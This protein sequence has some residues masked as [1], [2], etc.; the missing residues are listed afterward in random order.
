VMRKRLATPMTTP[1]A[2]RALEALAA[3]AHG[4]SQPHPMSSSVE[5]PSPPEIASFG[6]HLQEMSGTAVD[7]KNAPVCFTAGLSALTAL[8]I[9]LTGGGGADVLMSSTAY[10]GSSQV[11][12]LLGARVPACL[13][14]HTFD[15]QGGA[16]ITHNVQGALAR[17]RD[18]YAAQGKRPPRAEVATTVLFVEAPTNPDMKVPDLPALA[19]ALAKHATDVGTKA[20]L[21][22]DTT[23]APG[24][25]AMAK[26]RQA[27]PDLPVIVLL[28][29]SKS[30]SRGLTTAGALI[31]NG[32]PYACELLG[33]SRDAGDLLQTVATADQMRRLVD[34][35][36]GCEARCARAYETAMRVG[37][38]LQGAVK[39]RTGASLVLSTV[40]AAAAKDGQASTTFSFNL[41]RPEGASDD[42]VAG[43]AQ[44]FV[45]L[46]CTDTQR[47]KPC[48]SFGQDN[49]KVYCTVPATSTQGAI[50][51]EDKAKQ[52]VG[53]VQ[54]VRLSFPPSLD[55]QAACHVVSRA[56]EGCYR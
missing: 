49:G 30:V 50:K 13:H 11:T 46:L 52:A 44:K 29:M 4:G 47:F 34:N 40:S 53:G 23:L 17:I 16:Q 15:L 9:A 31:A 26:V 33:S 2:I 19:R 37:S 56:V 5:A 39:Q 36:V 22:V 1:M 8:W 41:P 43:L 24:A 42:E 27:V 32:T 45:D 10:G 3:H 20:L 51:S 14:K 55:E 25:G 21:L 54:L 12:D 35:H 28:S 6:A 48:V 7:S 38:H 18:A